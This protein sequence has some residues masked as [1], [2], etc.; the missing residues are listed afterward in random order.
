M[1]YNIINLNQPSVWK[2]ELTDI[3]HSY[4]HTWE[5]ADAFKQEGKENSF[6][7]LIADKKNKMV[8]ALTKREKLSGYPEIFSPYGFG[9]VIFKNDKKGHQAIYD[10]WLKFANDNGIITAF[11]LQH[12]LLTQDNNWPGNIFKHHKTYSINLTN[13]LN[14]LWGNLKKNH[15]Y[16]IKRLSENK[17]ITISMD[18][19][20]LFPYAEQLYS[21]T[22]KR[23]GASSTYSFHS[24]TFKKLFFTPSSLVLGALMN[25]KVQAIILILHTLKTAEYFLNAVDKTEPN[26]TKL[27]LWHAIDILK[28]QNVEVFNLGG[29]VQSNDQLSDFKR[30]FGGDENHSTIIKEV[31]DQRK[32]QYLCDYFKT[33]KDMTKGY[34]PSYWQPT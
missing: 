31:F 28:K 27:L 16:E 6:L 13:P 33:S 34:F 18:K 11:T 12:P 20:F 2:H 7:L 21:S 30:R 1:D 29:G 4:Y 22:L 8:C 14:E 24:E 32:Y 19:N 15:R 9:G 26:S 3:P 25:G 10:T 5:Y 23:V 17:S